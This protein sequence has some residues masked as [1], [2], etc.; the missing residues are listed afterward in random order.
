MYTRIFSIIACTV[1]AIGAMAAETA[2]SVLKHV[3]DQMSSSPV[4]AAFTVTGSG[5]SQEGAITM[6]G[7]KF[8]VTTSDLSTWYDGKTQWTLS[9][10]VKEVNVTEPSREELAEIN[11]LIILSALSSRFSAEMGQSTAD[12]YSILLSR[13]DND[14]G[15]A[16]ATVRVNATTWNPVAIT[17]V[18]STG[19]RF[20][21][22]IKSIKKLKSITD[23]TFRFNP[24]LYPGVEVI[25]LR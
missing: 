6:S 9:Q 13:R 3:V 11:P 7:N 17:I 12:S 21:I 4:Q 23:S 1:I 22:D 16:S 2:S 25:D 5:M 14:T 19:E 10:A 20:T 24:A 8:V 18:T 15:I